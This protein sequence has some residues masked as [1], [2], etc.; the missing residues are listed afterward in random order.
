VSRPAGQCSQP[1]ELLDLYPTLN[2]LCGLPPRRELEG[3]S[4][5]PLLRDPSAAWVKPA[6]TSDGP[7][8]ISVRTRQWRYSRFPDG[9]ELYDHQ[10]DPHEWH[11]LA[12]QPAHAGRK[13]ELAALLPPNPSRK[14]LRNWGRLSPEEKKLVRLPAG[15]HPLPD[16]QND[17]GLKPLIE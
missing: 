3:R 10:A 14:K 13:R 5:R 12:A 4:L 16:A 11:N 1:V 17:I 7:D 6:I 8:K 2:D 15:R 9:E